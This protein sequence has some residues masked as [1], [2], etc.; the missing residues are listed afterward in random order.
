LPIGGDA[1]YD[2]LHTGQQTNKIFERPF[3]YILK[4][5]KM[6]VWPI[7]SRFGCAHFDT[8]SMSNLLND[9][10]EEL[11]NYA[12]ANQWPIKKFGDLEAYKINIRYK[13]RIGD[14]RLLGL[15][16]LFNNTHYLAV[17]THADLSDAEQILNNP[18][19]SLE[20]H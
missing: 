14:S 18:Y 5:S 3:Q 1:R 12:S 16:M 17:S 9:R 13:E 19:S 6:D 10:L 4:K 11:N 7:Q 8:A 20:T 2:Y 15:I